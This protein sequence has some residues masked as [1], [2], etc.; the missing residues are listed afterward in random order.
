MVMNGL[1][2]IV[3]NDPW[4]V[5]VTFINWK[6][7]CF[8]ISWH[9]YTVS[10]CLKVWQIQSILSLWSV[11]VFHYSF[12]SVTAFRLKRSFPVRCSWLFSWIFST[13]SDR[14]YLKTV[15]DCQKTSKE[16]WAPRNVHA[17]GDKRSETF[18]K[19]RILYNFLNYH[20]ILTFHM[21]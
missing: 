14:F 17:F 13:V 5:T 6:I 1:K 7:F 9:K 8:L 21:K 2:R 19:S 18:E 20:R 16:R 10:S 15:R 11:N 4:T 12:Q 3:K